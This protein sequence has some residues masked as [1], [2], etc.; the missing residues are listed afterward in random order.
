A[1]RVCCQ[2]KLV[3]LFELGLKVSDLL[4][5][6][7]ANDV[8]RSKIILGVHAQACPSFFFKLRRNISCTTRQV[9]NMADLGLNDVVFTKV[10]LNLLRLCSCILVVYCLSLCLI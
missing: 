10:W 4:F 8:E 9:A 1:V 2:I 7:R 3:T 6:I 5:L